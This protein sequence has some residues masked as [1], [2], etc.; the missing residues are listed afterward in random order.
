M[1]VA[2]AI[3]TIILLTAVAAAGMAPAAAPTFAT[4][5]ASIR[6]AAVPSGTASAWIIVPGRGIGPVRLGISEPD[7][8]QMLGRPSAGSRASNQEIFEFATHGL[9]VWMEGG[10]VVRVRTTNAGHTT[11]SGFGPGGPN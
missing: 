4:T 3:R 9:T 8:R 2:L 5:A 11:A 10:R 6:V 1:N 7:L